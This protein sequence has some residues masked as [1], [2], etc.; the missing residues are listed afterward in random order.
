MLLREQ[1]G[2]MQNPQTHALFSCRR[3]IQKNHG[4]DVRWPD[5]YDPAR[6]LAAIAHVTETTGNGIPGRLIMVMGGFGPRNRA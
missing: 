4:Y 6:I 3:G 1:A 2:H 5:P